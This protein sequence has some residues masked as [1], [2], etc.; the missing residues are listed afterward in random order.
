MKL[1]TGFSATDST[2]IAVVLGA[3]L[4]TVGG[5]V[6]T[7]MEAHF[8]RRE[9]ERNAALLFGELLS[10]MEILLG[11]AKDAHG[12]GDPYGSVTLRVLRAARRE[13]ELYDRNREALYDLRVAETRAAIHSLMVRLTM[14]ID[15]VFDATQEIAALST[16]RASAPIQAR[17]D[18]LAAARDVGFEFVME[19]AQRIRPV[20]EGLSPLARQ[21]FE[22]HQRTARG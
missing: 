17:I 15:G 19:V 13:I 2:L 9:R 16:R 10:T 6:A 21:N 11:A 20:V 7:Q 5:F 18:E 8:R 1:E 3:V 22:A 12:V 4:A 14:P